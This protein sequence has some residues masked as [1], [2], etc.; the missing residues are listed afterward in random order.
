[1][2]QRGRRT[3]ALLAVV[4]VLGVLGVARSVQA[5][6]GAEQE[7]LQLERDWCTA[8]TKR[9]AA[10]L[11]RILADDF[12]GVT[13]RGVVQTK[14]DALAGLKDQ[15]SGTDACVD[16]DMKVRVYGDAA[17]VTGLGTRSGTFEG[18]PFKDRQ[19]LW[20]DTFVKK[21]GRWQCVASQGTV[22]AAQ[23]K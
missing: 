8:T 6:G 10:L 7:L 13:N 20:T 11:G 4:Y 23:Q 16:K 12:T 17:V 3:S 5:Q 22:V 9:D 15:K 14:A 2:E 18:Q 1:M 21:D 19:F